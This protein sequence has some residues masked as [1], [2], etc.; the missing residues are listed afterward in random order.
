MTT[1]FS[2]PTPRK[3][4]TDQQRA[5]LF[6]DL[7]GQCH[8]CTRPIRPGEKWIAEHV[9]A[10]QNGGTNEP[11]NWGLTCSNCLPV[12]NAEDAKIAAKARHVITKHLVPSDQRQ[13]KGRPLAGC[14]SSGWKHKVSGQ[15]E[16]R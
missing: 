14:K 1:A 8:K 2:P 3:V 12:K 7:S 10:L 4:L 9:R 15:W 16:K 13:R 6:L 5:K 11:E